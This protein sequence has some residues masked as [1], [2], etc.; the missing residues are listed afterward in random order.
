MVSPNTATQ[1]FMPQNPF[2]QL[3]RDINAVHRAADMP[4]SLRYFAAILRS[5]PAILVTRSLAPADPKMASVPLRIRVAGIEYD[6]SSAPFGGVREIYLRRVYFPTDQFLPGPSELVI[7]LGANIGLFSLFCARRGAEVVA[8]EAQSGFGPER[9]S[10]LQKNRC[11]E[12]VRSVCAL[13][14]PE[15]GLFADLET[16]RASS[17][18]SREPPA[19]TMSELLEQYG[20]RGVALVK[21]D[22]EGSEFALFSHDTDWLDRVRRVAMEVHCR[23]GDPNALCTRLM[24]AGFRTWLTD[25]SGQHVASLTG[26]G[27]YCFAERR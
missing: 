20:E 21:C 25:P 23:F 7:D 15:T 24:Q 4:T 6:L 9:L 5:M 2:R 8:V 1:L 18:F 19:V 13:V 16:L 26:E 27:G 12:R 17:H 10:L 22:I 3:W 14:G 11:A